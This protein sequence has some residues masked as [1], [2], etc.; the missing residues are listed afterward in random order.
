MFPALT[1]DRLTLMNDALAVLDVLDAQAAPAAPLTAEDRKAQ[2][3]ALVSEVTRKRGRE[4][5]AAAIAQAVDHWLT[6]VPVTSPTLARPSAWM[7]AKARGVATWRGVAKT[8]ATHDGLRTFT[9]GMLLTVGG[10]LLISLTPWIATVQAPFIL[11]ATHGTAYLMAWTM[12]MGLTITALVY[13]G[14]KDAEA[15][16]TLA[17]FGLTVLVMVGGL[18][19]LLARQTANST[20]DVANLRQ[21]V[22]RLQAAYATAEGRLKSTA[23]QAD[24]V[25]ASGKILSSVHTRW[26]FDVQRNVMRTEVDLNSIECATLTARAALPFRITTVNGQAAGDGP[27]ACPFHWD[28]T[29]QIELPLPHRDA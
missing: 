13:F 16:T 14:R 19:A 12:A 4:H 21:D 27:L 10:A 25:E 6:P 17:V 7:R 5:S 3:V 9:K 8:W 28:N 23:S 11:A 15:P 18:G 22:S 2:L 1:T 24:V 26:V 20:D 29:V